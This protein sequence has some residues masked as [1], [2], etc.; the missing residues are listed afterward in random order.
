M[1]VLIFICLA[2]VLIWKFY[3]LYYSPTLTQRARLMELLSYQ[4]KESGMFRES[5]VWSNLDSEEDV[6]PGSSNSKI[7]EKIKRSHY[8]P[9]GKR[10]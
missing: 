10:R 4:A 9:L 6:V 1:I 7:Q 3:R 5:Y 8:A 2:P